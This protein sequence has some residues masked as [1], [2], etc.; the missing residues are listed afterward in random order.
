MMN[1]ILKRRPRPLVRQKREVS[2]QEISVNP[3]GLLIV[4]GGVFTAGCGIVD[5]EWAMTNRRA[6]FLSRL[7]TRTGA[8]AFYGVVG[9]GMIVVGTL[10]TIGVIVDP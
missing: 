8:R 1:C 3:I 5:W 7:I 2:R 10:M 9:A 4:V 6:R